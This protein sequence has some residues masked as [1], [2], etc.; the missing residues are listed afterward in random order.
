[1]IPTFYVYI[2]DEVLGMNN[3]NKFRYCMFTLCFEAC[4]HDFSNILMCED[5]GNMICINHTYDQALSGY[6]DDL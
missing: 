3:V 2:Y 5:I 1:M 6:V 4:L